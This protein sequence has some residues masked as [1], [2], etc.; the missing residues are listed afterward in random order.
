MGMQEEQ[1]EISH[2][3]KV[4]L[5]GKALRQKLQKDFITSEITDYKM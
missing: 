2:S 3:L 1:T 5:L 4:E